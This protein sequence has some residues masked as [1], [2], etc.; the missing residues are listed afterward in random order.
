M[1]IYSGWIRTAVAIGRIVIGII[2]LFR[3]WVFSLAV[4]R[5]PRDSEGLP[6]T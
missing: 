1:R 2:I 4:S 5:V 6:R 3:T